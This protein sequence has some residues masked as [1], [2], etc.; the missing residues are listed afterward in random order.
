MSNHTRG[1][2][3]RLVTAVASRRFPTVQADRVNRAPDTGREASA[4]ID[5]F[6][7]R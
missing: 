5:T 2:I 6:S 7:Y 3:D 1:R 4:G